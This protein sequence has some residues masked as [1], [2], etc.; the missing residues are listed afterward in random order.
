MHF[1]ASPDG[2]K[3]EGV[4]YIEPEKDAPVITPDGDVIVVPALTFDRA[5][6]RMER[7]R[8]ITTGFEKRLYFNRSC[9][10]LPSSTIPR[11]EH[12][13]RV[14]ILVTDREI[15]CFPEAKCLLSAVHDEVI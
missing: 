11:Q 9:K 5:G 10:R 14:G 3:T 1:R 4:R 2:L 15:L 6:F 13:M 8:V 7:E 12:D